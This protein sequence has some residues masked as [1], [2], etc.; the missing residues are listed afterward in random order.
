MSPRAAANVLWGAARLGFRHPELLAAA[1]Q[2]LGPQVQSLAASD[3]RALTT[4]LWALSSLRYRP[5]EQLLLAAAAP[6]ATRLELFDD[7]ALSNLLLAYARMGV[8]APRLFSA[9]SAELARRSHFVDLQSL[10]SCTWALAT[11]GHC[12]PPDMARIA[13]VLTAGVGAG[14]GAGVGAGASAGAAAPAAWAALAERLLQCGGRRA[15]ALS[16]LAWSYASMGVAHDQLTAA[17]LG[18]AIAMEGQQQ[19]AAAAGAAAPAEAA[20]AG[21]EKG[22]AGAAGGGSAGGEAERHQRAGCLLRGPELC[23][24]AYSAAVLMPHLAASHPELLQALLSAIDRYLA[25]PVTHDGDG[26]VSTQVGVSPS[27]ALPPAM[28]PAEAAASGPGPGVGA[29]AVASCPL[30]PPAPPPGD[31]ALLSWA[32]A[33][34]DPA[35]PTLHSLL[36]AAAAAHAA[37]PPP[38]G[39]SLAEDVEG[40]RLE[41]A[42]AMGPKGS[43]DAGGVEGAFGDDS[44]DGGEAGDAGFAARDPWVGPG[45]FQQ[46]A[47]VGSSSYHEYGLSQLY[48]ANYV[49]CLAAEAA[50]RAGQE[51]QEAEA[52]AGAAHAQSVARLAAAAMRQ[53][54]AEAGR[55]AE[56]LAA[57]DSSAYAA[58]P[59][60]RAGTRDGAGELLAGH[61][62]YT[63]A[64]CGGGKGAGD[65]KGDGCE[66]LIAFG[67]LASSPALFCAARDAWYQVTT[68][69]CGSALHAAVASALR[70]AAAAGTGPAAAAGGAATTD[71]GGAGRGGGCSWLV[72]G[73]A[74]EALS[75]DRMLRVDLL[76]R[77]GNWLVLIQVDG[78]LHFAKEL[79]AGAGPPSGSQPTVRAGTGGAGGKGP[80]D[81][82]APLP[83]RLRRLGATVLRDRLLCDALGL[84]G[85]G[86]TRTDEI[87]DVAARGDGMPPRDGAANAAGY[88]CILGRVGGPEA[89]PWV[90]ESL[91][92]QLQSYGCAHTGRRREDPAAAGAGAAVLEVGVCPGLG[93]GQ[94]PV[95]GVAAVVVSAAQWYACGEDKWTDYLA[96][97]LRSACG[98]AA[99]ANG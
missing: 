87:V 2:T 22:S 55:A 13:D 31:L 97:L 5:A 84:Q 16:M 34:L 81:G 73:V 53:A 96:P 83:G 6:A 86:G 95:R 27:S 21:V 39:R 59:G 43:S 78:P 26:A 41:V 24:L 20:E 58:R 17:L 50:A 54:E 99:A 33:V 76:V 70:T 30:A 90:I 1:V 40:S 56:A 69:T 74:E 46:S 37:R 75:P 93:P 51:G 23:Q 11:A 91:Q 92:G 71:G 66:H 60:Q 64:A 67:P 47:A 62:R 25:L 94:Q 14:A 18:A 57:G 88:G 85:A 89:D 3:P 44:G 19:A 35:S 72:G 65:W 7:Q 29:A 9:A 77:Y 52:G 36:T 8:P 15:Q 63:S 82:P 12:D 4:C 79:G 80:A 48:L 61:E 28:T 49:A 42:A 45:G 68:A 38:G 98:V 10:A 32:V